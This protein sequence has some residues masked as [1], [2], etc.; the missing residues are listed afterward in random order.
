MVRDFVD[1]VFNGSGRPLVVHLLEDD[2]LSESELR[3]ITRMLG[4]KR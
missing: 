2:Q 1:R 3:E 4:K